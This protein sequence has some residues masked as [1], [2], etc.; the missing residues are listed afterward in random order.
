M[1]ILIAP[2]SFKGSLTSL[3]VAENIGKGFLRVFPEAEILKVPMA[4]GGEGTLQSLVD[5]YKGEI[6]KERVTGPL[7]EEVEA[8][9]GLIENGFTGVI[10]IAAASG[11]T[12][13]P[14]EKRNPMKTT[15]YG[16]GQL[17]KRAL[18][19]GVRKLIIGIGGSATNDAGVGMAQALGVK[20][21]DKDGKEIGYGGAELGRIERIDMSL[22]EPRIK[23]VD[24]RVACDVKNRLYGREGAAYVYGPQKG[25]S[26]EMVMILDE[27][28]RHF[29]RIV[30]RELGVELQSIE[31][32]GAAGGL[33]A[34]LVA[35]LKAKLEAGIDIVMDAVKLEEKMKKADLVITGEG[36]IDGQTVNGKTPIGV[37]RKARKY[38]IPVIAISAI[39][40]EGVEKVLYEGIDAVFNIM[41]RPVSIE[42][43][44]TWEWLQFVS[45]QIGRVLR[46]GK[47]KDSF[48]NQK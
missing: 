10:E 1:K 41:Q 18:E 30:E 6:I 24:I 2:D 29:S 12:L 5:A 21:L 9:Y 16:T 44:P 4:D 17:I 42:E 40:G 14:E 47:I 25:A 7:G 34:G 23:E 39:T 19:K 43:Q 26:P 32:G 37:A 35:F 28:L 31:G 8:Y 20:F 13:V 27:N 22:L 33:G 38:G 3:G 46:L 36:C 48:F 11:L 15:T 45:E